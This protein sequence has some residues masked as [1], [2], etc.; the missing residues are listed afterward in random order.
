MSVIPEKV[1]S[2][3]ERLDSSKTLW[4]AYSGGADSTVLL[5]AAKSAAAISG[6]KLKAIHVN[7]QI[8]SDS[9]LWSDF[10]AQQC[11]LISV[12]LKNITINVDSIAELGIEG[13]ARHARYRAFEQCL[14][15][16][17]VLF[18]AHHADDQIET[19]LMQLFR[20]AGVQGL[21]GCAAQP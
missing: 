14:G 11:E 8:H 6:H 1:S 12:P 4:I 21:T 9:Q 10:C 7:H 2:V 16:N 18:T 3:F 17:D 13:A 5:H 19:I 20:G 15:K